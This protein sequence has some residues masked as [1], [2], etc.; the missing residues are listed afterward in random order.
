MPAADPLFK[1]TPSAFGPRTDIWPRA[2]HSRGAHAGSHIQKIRQIN[3]GET[4]L[5][6]LFKKQHTA[7]KKKKS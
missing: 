5:V 2:G 3:T 4:P 1:I 6:N 7:K